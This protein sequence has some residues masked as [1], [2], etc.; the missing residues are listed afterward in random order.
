MPAPASTPNGVNDYRSGHSYR[1]L[2]HRDFRLLWACDGISTAGTQI[3][4][5]AVAWQVFRLTNDPLHLGLLGL[6]RFLPIVVFGLIGGVAADRG[7]RRRTL[8][9]TQILLLACSGALAL[10]TWA[11]AISIAAIYA[12]VILAATVDS[13]ANPTRQ[14]LIP[15]LVPREE[16]PAASTMN[17][18][19]FHLSTIGGPAVGGILI[20]WL[21]VGSAYFVDAVSFGAVIFA[22]LAMHARPVLVPASTGGLAAAKEGL[23]FLKRSP[24]LLGV[25]MTDFFGAFFGFSSSL[26]PIFAEDVLHSGPR[27]LGLLYS[28][29]AVGGVLSAIVL[30]IIRLPNRAGLTIL[31]AI[32]LYGGCMLGFGL[33]TTL[34]LSLLFLAF[35]GATDSISMTL[36]HGMR[37]ILTPDPL[38]GRV[39]AV[40]R[41]LSGGGPQLGEFEAGLLAAV[42]GAGPAVAIGGAASVATAVVAAKLVPP[43]VSFRF[44]R[45]VAEPPE[46][47][48]EPERPPI[49]PMAGV[50]IESVSA[51]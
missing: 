42:I 26:M 11:N 45:A 39:A 51:D 31:V 34:W 8:L 37:Q 32:G 21:G 22:V 18:I 30:S 6:C 27:G 50:A 19:D 1:V 49:D 12:I 38:R 47:E 48:I 44:S 25:M 7:D 2:R 41:M 15:V 17:L 24:V 4:R 20:A 5:I 36:R 3:Q 23:A 14:A 33:S 29:P 13:I 16:L 9:V 46:L 28:A 40:H 10:L 43:I 35:S